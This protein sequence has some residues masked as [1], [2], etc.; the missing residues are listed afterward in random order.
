M[1]ENDRVTVVKEV[2]FLN[3]LPGTPWLALLV[4]VV[5]VKVAVVRLVQ[6]WNAPLVILVP[7]S[8]TVF[9]VV[10]PANC[11]PSVILGT[12]MVRFTTLAIPVASELIPVILPSMVTLLPVNAVTTLFDTVTPL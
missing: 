9:S 10:L 12:V 6:P 3:V 7:F 8:V 11:V 5:L 1:F 2:Q 4:F